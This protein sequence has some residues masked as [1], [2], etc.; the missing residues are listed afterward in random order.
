MLANDYAPDGM[1][2]NLDIISA[3]SSDPRVNV[4]IVDG[5]SGELLS[6][7][8]ADDFFPI[9]G[10]TTSEDVIVEYTIDGGGPPPMKWSV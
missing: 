9:E 1:P 7:S 4:A 2:E 6:V 5:P 8:V 3:S 10:E